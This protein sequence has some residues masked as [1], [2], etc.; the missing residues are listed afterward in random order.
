MKGSDSKIAIVSLVVLSIWIFVALPLIYSPE[1]TT[2]HLLRFAPLFTPVV[3]SVAAIIAVAAISAQ[4]SIARK[5][6]AIDFFL[7]TDLDHNM[8]EAYADFEKALKSFKA[9]T[10]GGRDIKTFID[11]PETEKDYKKILRYLNVH[12]L[13][14]VGIKNNIFD[15]GVCYN[16]WSD[17]MVR[18]VRETRPVIEYEIEDGGSDA[19]FLELRTLSARWS[20]Q[21]ANWNRNF[22]N[23]RSVKTV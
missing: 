4:K 11:D 7:K 9:H 18:H 12:E 23:G 1:P 19:L 5:R 14:A 6:A 2:D 17:A 22:G 13:V 15:E 20:V 10:A 16:F 8:L 21:I 3:A